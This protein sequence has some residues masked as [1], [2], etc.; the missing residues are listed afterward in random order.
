MKLIKTPDQFRQELRTSTIKPNKLY[1]QYMMQEHGFELGFV[2]LSP[3]S[4]R[5][6]IDNGYMLVQKRHNGQYTLKK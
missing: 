4:V 5:K 1:R 6:Y 3:E 2:A